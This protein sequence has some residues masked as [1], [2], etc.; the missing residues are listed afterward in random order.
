MRL[1][2]LAGGTAASGLAAVEALHAIWTV[3]PWPP[4]TRADFART[5]VG[6][7]ETDLPPAGP[8]V[9]AALGTVAYLVAAQARLV[10]LAAPPRLIPLGAWAVA[11]VMLA[12]GAAGLPS[13]GLTGRPTDY[14]SWDLALYSPL[15]LALGG[16]AV[17]VAAFPS[18]DTEPA[19]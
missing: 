6:V 14:T 10:P 17:C 7:T 5:V 8:T 12:R 18:K 4:A 3:S 16:L 15:C 19:R 13:S 2:K 9:A 11:G 1:T